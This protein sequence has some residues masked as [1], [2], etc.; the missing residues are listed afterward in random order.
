MQKIQEGRKTS[1]V[2]LEHQIEKLDKIAERFEITRSQAMRLILETGLD[3]YEF[4]SHLG[5]TKLAEILKKAREAHVSRKQ[6]KLPLQ[7]IK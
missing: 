3:S 2:L 4:Y 1:V 7:P 6:L 5:V